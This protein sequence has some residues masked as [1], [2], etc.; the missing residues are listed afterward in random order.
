MANSCKYLPALSH[1]FDLNAVEKGVEALRVGFF[2]S[3][4][5][6]TGAAPPGP[7]RAYATAQ[8]F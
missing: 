5:T 6:P 1:L 8:T 7:P 3:G 4:E 2:C